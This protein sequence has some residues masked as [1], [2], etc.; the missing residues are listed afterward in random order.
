[1]PPEA[2][3][4]AAETTNPATVAGRCAR[5]VSDSTILRANSFRPAVPRSAIG[6]SFCSSSGGTPVGISA[7]NLF[8]HYR[9]VLAANVG[10]RLHRKWLCQLCD[11]H[12]TRPP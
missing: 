3:T 1:M 12:P 2:A 10:S 9:L 4:R 11:Q 6:C 5:A 8:R 7:V